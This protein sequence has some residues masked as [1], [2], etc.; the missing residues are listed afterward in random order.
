MYVAPSEVAAG[1]GFALARKYPKYAERERLLGLFADHW[2]RAGAR[3]GEYRGRRATGR[4]PYTL[5]LSDG[6]A[7]EPERA[8]LARYANFARA[9]A[10]ANAEFVE[11]GGR[12]YLV[13]TRAIAP[14]AEILTY[15]AHEPPARPGRNAAIAYKHLERAQEHAGYGDDDKRQR[16][17]RRAKRFARRALREI[18]VANAAAFGAAPQAATKEPVVGACELRVGRLLGFSDPARVLG[19]TRGGIPN[20]G[21]TSYLSAALQCLFVT[22]FSSRATDLDSAYSKL[23][24]ECDQGAAATETTRSVLKALTDQGALGREN[25]DSERGVHLPSFLNA[26]FSTAEKGMFDYGRRVT[27][28]YQGVLVTDSKLILSGNVDAGFRGF[29]ELDAD[30]ARGHVDPKLIPEFEEERM[31]ELPVHPAKYRDQAP[32]NSLEDAL[33]REFGATYWPGD[34]ISDRAR[35]IAIEYKNKWVTRKMNVFPDVLC[36]AL[37]PKR[38]ELAIPHELDASPYA[39]DGN[40]EYALAAVIAER[41]GHFVAYTRRVGLWSRYDDDKTVVDVHPDYALEHAYVLFYVRKQRPRVAGMARG[42]IPNIGGSCCIGSNL[43]CLFVTPDSAFGALK[44]PYEALKRQCA[45]GNASKQTTEMFRKALLETLE[46]SAKVGDAP[47]IHDALEKRGALDAELLLN[48][49]LSFCEVCGSLRAHEYNKNCP[50]EY[51][52][53][54]T[55]KKKYVNKVSVKEDTRADRVLLAFASNLGQTLESVLDEQFTLEDNGTKKDAHGDYS[56]ETDAK[57]AFLPE[58]LCVNV[59]PKNNCRFSLDLDM[60]EYTREKQRTEFELVAVVSYEEPEKENEKDGHYVASVRHAG[61]WWRFDD[62][63]KVQVLLILP[64][65][66]VDD[67]VLLFYRRK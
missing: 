48:V 57:I 37:K 10:D 45:Q 8:C 27:I 5:E 4:G 59:A 22:S 67:A 21:D 58:V 65:T 1:F 23:K 47:R 36:I 13:A 43:Q 11:R 39:R 19:S 34:R 53:A 24:A 9:E 30:E 52:V 55:V 16:H 18:G 26:L 38:S 2:V 25:M 54:T 33:A 63:K 3:L 40:A 31:L 20:L 44:E 61:T 60:A 6:S 62:D 17:E 15:M 56:Q 50:F 29:P 41:R 35:E 14:H 42:G 28:R 64:N 51:Q 7:I 32:V 12:A 49:L 46:K 66:T